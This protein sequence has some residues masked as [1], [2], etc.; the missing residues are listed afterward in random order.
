M[1]LGEYGWVQTHANGFYV[2]P[3]KVKILETGCS[4]IHSVK[5]ITESGAVHYCKPDQIKSRPG[6]ALK[7]EPAIPEEAKKVAEK[8]ADQKIK[9]F[10]EKK[11]EEMKTMEIITE[12]QAA[13]R[14]ERKN[15]AT[16]EEVA[17]AFASI[18]RASDLEPDHPELSLVVDL[19]TEQIRSK[20]AGGWEV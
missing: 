20:Y 7:A 12:K 10:K 13:E 19:A 6:K 1:K 14:K 17:K 16:F 4:G 18:A 2:N 15:K 9:E 5:V 8:I 3:V 11:A